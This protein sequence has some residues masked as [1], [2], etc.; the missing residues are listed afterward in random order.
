LSV[1]SFVFIRQTKN[2]KGDKMENNTAGSC[3]MNH[4]GGKGEIGKTILM[5]HTVYQTGTIGATL[6]NHKL[7]DAAPKPGDV[8]QFECDETSLA[9]K[10]G[11]Y[12]YPARSFVA[13]R[14]GDIFKVGLE[15]RPAIEWLM[16]HYG[17][18]GIS[19]TTDIVYDY[20]FF[21]DRYPDYRLSV[22]FFGVEANRIRPDEKRL[23]AT[24][25]FNSKNN[26]M[27]LAQAIGVRT[28][29][30]EFFSSAWDVDLGKYASRK[31]PLV[32][33]ISNSVSGLGFKKCCNVTDLISVLEK[34]EKI[35]NKTEWQIQEF[36][37]GAKFLSAQWWIDEIG[38]S[39][40]IT[41]TCN[42]IE[43][44]GNHAGNWSDTDIPHEGLEKFTSGIA[45]RGA[46]MGLRDWIGFDVAFYRGKFYL[47]EC[48]PRYTGAAYPFVAVQK[49]FGAEATKVFWAHKSY[50]VNR[51]SINEFSL[52]GAEYDPEKGT[53]WIVINP[54]PLTVG[55]GKIGALWIGKKENYEKEEDR[56]K[57]VLA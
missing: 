53:G 13:S 24:K 25:F 35:P 33:K 41:G 42:F 28:P 47:I 50:D 34:I 44:E 37:D 55:D 4:I 54:G 8:I 2:E 49:L 15:L 12:S 19:H 52:N 18:I 27:K 30:T 3:I 21:P 40:F 38:Q 48:N 17:R 46:Q 39:H 26:V 16:D 32:A 7:D 10:L 29:A 23:F 43:G 5:N 1:K 36:L 56:L 57:N 45:M 9:Q 20:D 51:K 31:F 14:P 22:F 6:H 11:L